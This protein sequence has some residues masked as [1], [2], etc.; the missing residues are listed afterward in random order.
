MNYG[1]NYENSQNSSVFFQNHISNLVNDLIEKSNIRD[2]K[3]LEI[4]CGDGYFLK[5]LVQDDSWNKCRY[6]L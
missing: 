6:W 1:D 2:S 5:Q 4:G 3:I